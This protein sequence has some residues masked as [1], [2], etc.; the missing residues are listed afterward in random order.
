MYNFDRLAN[1]VYKA[2]NKSN[3]EQYALI[4]KNDDGTAEVTIHTAK[5]IHP[6]YESTD[7]WNLQ[8]KRLIQKGFDV[9]EEP[10]R[11]WGGSRENAGRPSTGRKKHQYYVTDEEDAEIK[12]LI[13]Q[14]RKPTE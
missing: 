13:E 1:N 9:T 6:I 11:Y 12:K 3:P 7:E 2:D 4:L 8:L 14:L 10:P 5:S